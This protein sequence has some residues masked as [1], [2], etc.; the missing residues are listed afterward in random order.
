MLMSMK[1]NFF[2]L[3]VMLLALL[4]VGFTSCGDDDEPK[5]ADIV[6]TWAYLTDTDGGFAIL[7]QFT[8]DGMFHEVI[9]STLV[10]PLHGKYTVSGHQLF[11][12]Y[13][14]E[15][16]TSTVEY[17]YSVQGDKLILYFEGQGPV[18]FT[19]VKD[20]VIEPYL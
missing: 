7:F 4:A 18:T 12:T 5:G 1:K 3:M 16:E 15:N 2:A 17:D 20:S 8:K 19:R 9:N 6:G 10:N 14:F 11:I 13:I